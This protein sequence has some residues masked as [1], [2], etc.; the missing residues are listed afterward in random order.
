MKL[1]GQIIAA[2]GRR[3]LV[4]L[5]DGELLDCVPRGK[6]SEVAC[7]DLV[8]IQRTAAQ[9]S[10]LKTGAQGVIDRSQW[11]V[12]QWGAFA[13]NDVQIGA[14]A[15]VRRQVHPDAGTVH[16]LSFGLR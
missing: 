3:Y 15:V 4:E 7:G 12:S 6:K 1:Q 2:F 14:G 11:G 10:D 16:R 13:G 5:A 9:T 8:E